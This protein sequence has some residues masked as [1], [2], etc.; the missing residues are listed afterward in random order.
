MTATAQTFTLY[1]E[2][3]DMGCDAR[4]VIECMESEDSDFESGNYRFIHS[5]CIDQILADEMEA[6]EYLLGCFASWAIA[7]AT[8]W[9]IA[10]IEAAQKAE[11]FQEIGEAMTKE[12]IYEL[13][14]VLANTDGYGHH[15]SSYDGATLEFGDYFAFRTN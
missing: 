5:G 15:F 13:G 6:D 9:P 2:L 14:Q 4:E 1:R 12:Q 3:A 7:D 8:G 11:D 10:L